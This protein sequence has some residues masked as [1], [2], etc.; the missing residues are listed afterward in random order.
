MSNTDSRIEIIS[1]DTLLCL[2][3]TQPSER[4]LR[5]QFNIPLDTIEPLGI[6]LT[7]ETPTTPTQIVLSY[8]KALRGLYSLLLD[9]ASVPEGTY[10]SEV[11]LD[12]GTFIA[13]KDLKVKVTT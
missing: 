3:Q 4:L 11:A 9:P 5:I 2:K 6:T 12:Y 13:S 8:T 1:F 7:L 10:A